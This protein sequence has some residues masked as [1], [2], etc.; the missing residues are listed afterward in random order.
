M[1]YRLTKAKAQE[2]HRNCPSIALHKMGDYGH[3]LSDAKFNIGKVNGHWIEVHGRFGYYDDN[4][5]Q[6]ESE[7]AEHLSLTVCYF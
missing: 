5:K 3:I 1:S 7:I 4:E 6:T 2:F